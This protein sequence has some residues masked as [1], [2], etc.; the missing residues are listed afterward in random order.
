MKLRARLDPYLLALLGCVLVAAW[1]PAQ[2]TSARA[3]GW[4]TNLAIALLFFLYGARLSPQQALQ[5]ARNVRLHLTILGCTYVLFP[6]LG[7][8]FRL[9]FPE[10]LGADLSLGLSF[11]CAVPS[12]VQ[13]SIAFTSVA[14][15]NVAAALTSASLSN[16]LGVILTPLLVALTI[17]SAGAAAAS[18][19][20]STLQKLA[21]QLVLPFFAGQ[22]SRPWLAEFVERQRRPL[23]LV[24]RG[25]ILLVVYAAFSEGVTAGV[26]DAVSPSSLGWALLVDAG[27]LALVLWL[28]TRLSRWLGFSKEDE[29]AAVFCGSKKSLAS[30][31]PM[32]AVLFP[33][34]RASLLVLPLMLFHQL[35]L[36]ACAFLARRY[37][38]SWATLPAPRDSE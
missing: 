24:D 38:A 5:G 31:L 22:L 35:Q 1:F 13:S 8:G 23:G 29:I 19:W 26:W 9:A 34:D 20:L 3:L 27:L 7:V 28:T 2:G 14:R 4:V 11:L 18:P 36:M 16:L 25:S 33:P 37:A 30:G 21:L 15:G 32:A 17:D 6:C 10:L 12:T